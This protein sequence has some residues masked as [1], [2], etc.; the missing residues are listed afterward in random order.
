[1]RTPVSALVLTCIVLLAFGTATRAADRTVWTHD[2]G[3]FVKQEG[4]HWTEGGDFEFLEKDRTSKYVELYDGKRD[5][6]VRLYDDH[7]QI[8][9]DGKYVRLYKGGWKK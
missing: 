7:S 1:M 2:K 5:T 6:W 4:K 8:K 3:F 9:K